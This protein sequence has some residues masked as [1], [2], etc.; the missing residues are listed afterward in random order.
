[1]IRAQQNFQDRV[2]EIESYFDFIG[3][4]DAGT[5]LIIHSNSK[6]PAYSPTTKSDLMRTFRASAF[7]LLY[8][9]M[10]STVSNAIEAIF[11]EL[12]GQ[13]ISFDDCSEKVRKIVLEN[14]K[15]TSVKKSLPLLN[16]IATDI[17]T[18]TFRRD[19]VV[20]GNVDAAKI[21]ELA[22]DY[23]FA[24]PEVGQVWRRAADLGFPVELPSGGR[25]AGDGSTL[26]TVKT[27]RN[28]LAHGN[29]SFAEVGRDYTQAD[30]TRIKCEVIAYLDAVLQNVADYVTQQKYRV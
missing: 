29:A 26:L 3:T 20:S 10:E 13:S 21:R 1:M 27:H 5:A 17:V 22:D 6:A 14:L 16:S 2:R 4:V 15:S 11:D 12:K 9:L 24:R 7:L 28:K 30:I 18:N 19:E 25:L 8:N 23:G